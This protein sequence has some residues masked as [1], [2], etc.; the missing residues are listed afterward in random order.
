VRVLHVL[1]T[2]LPFIAGYTIR[3]DYIIRH[4]AERGMRPAVVTAAQH[5]NGDTL[6]E[7]IHGISYWRTPEPAGKKVP[8]V[9]ELLLMR[10]LEVR[11]E[12]AIREWRPDVVHAHSPMLVGLPALAAARRFGLPM[13]YEVR[14]LWE[15]ASVDRG[16]FAEDSPPY[17]AARGL[18]S[19]VFKYADATV[20]IC[21]SLRNE[22]A[23]RVRSQDALFVVGNGVDSDKFAPR[24]APLS[25]WERWGLSGKKI[26]GYV[27]TFQPY[28]GLQTLIASIG[29]IAKQVPEAHVV[30]TGAGGQE[31]ELKAFAKEKGLES[32]VTFTGR[33][34]HDEVFNIYAMASLLVYPR[35]LTRTTALTTPLKPL[36]AMA[37]ARAVMV[38][39]VPAM[40]ELVRYGETGFVFKA[41]D[42][43]DLAKRAV[44]A[45]KD[46]ARLAQVGKNAREWI[47]K[48]RQWP[49]LLSQYEKVYEKAIAARR[50]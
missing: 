4:Q 28:E 3:S 35:I 27:G 44:E 19:V 15:N 18:E 16:K 7:D 41:G 14:D 47:V 1:H 21:E 6:H 13:V 33:V 12:D 37:M 50:G 8:L 2:S 43:A 5:P 17:K 42:T 32:K 49:T 46:P 25:A 30:I 39:D 38:S 24:E 20:T 34:P 31:M 48:E 26:I 23:P 40:G 9:R 45:L 29:D 36:E 11:V 22:I 10:A